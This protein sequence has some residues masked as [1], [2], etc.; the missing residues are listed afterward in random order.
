MSRFFTQTRTGISDRPAMSEAA[1]HRLAALAATHFRGVY[2]CCRS[3]TPRVKRPPARR[4]RANTHGGLNGTHD[5]AG[6]D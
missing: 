6:R 4:H 1:L 5:N 3:P 2:Q